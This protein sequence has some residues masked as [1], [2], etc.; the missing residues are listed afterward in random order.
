MPVENVFFVSR[1]CSGG[2]SILLF[3]YYCPITSIQKACE[4]LMNAPIIRGSSGLL[5][6]LPVGFL[7]VSGILRL[8]E[9]IL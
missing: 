7:D 4:S 9:G 1:G 5:A 3:L 2:R 8:F 6:M